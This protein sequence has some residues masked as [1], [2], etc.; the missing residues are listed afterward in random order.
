VTIMTESTLRIA[1]ARTFA[2]RLGGLLARPPL[3]DDEA[4]Y[5]APCASVHTFFMRYAI[6]VVFVDR[7]G[8]VL[9]LA[10]LAPWRAAACRGA[11]GVLELRAGHARRHGLAPG[12][13]VNVDSGAAA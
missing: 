3:R 12:A 10:T 7:A 8:R 5:L 4:L 2:A 13:V 6:D 11:H 9:K 1:Q